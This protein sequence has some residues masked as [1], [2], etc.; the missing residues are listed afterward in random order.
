MAKQKLYTR[1]E[2]EAMTALNRAN[3]AKKLG[4][5]AKARAADEVVEMILGAQSETPIDGPETPSSDGKPTWGD[6][7]AYLFEMLKGML[8]SPKGQDVRA[9]AA[10]ALGHDEPIDV[11]ETAK[12]WNWMSTVLRRSPAEAVDTHG[13]YTAKVAADLSIELTVYAHPNLHNRPNGQ[14]QDGDVTLRIANVPEFLVLLSAAYVQG[15]QIVEDDEEAM[16][17]EEQGARDRAAASVE[18]DEDSTPG[19]PTKMDEMAAY[20]GVG[21]LTAPEL[22]AKVADAVGIVRKD[23]ESDEAFHS[24][25]AETFDTHLAGGKI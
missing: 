8:S 24:R 22:P 2:L 25:I 1:E 23:K 13:N 16:C 21:H 17:A 11:E 12:R 5:D 4:L 15:V 9:F 6:L 18:V 10:E 14:R 3:L 7:L 20:L 19:E